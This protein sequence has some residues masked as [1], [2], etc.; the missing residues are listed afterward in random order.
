MVRWIPLFLLLA[1]AN[2]SASVYRCERGGQLVFSDRACEA[3]QVAMELTSPNRLETS[4]GDRELARA[5]DA[6]T[7]SLREARASAM[8]GARASAA[9]PESAASPS[10]KDRKRPSAKRLKAPRQPSV[11]RTADKP[12][13][14]ALP[15]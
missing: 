10:H 14:L 11:P 4:P 3:G 5:F 15:R 12:A 7:A 8:V 1:C 13:K 9:E 2:A 6:R